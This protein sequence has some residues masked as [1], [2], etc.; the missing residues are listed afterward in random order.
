MG[1]VT[2]FLV[3]PKPESSRVHTRNYV[4]YLEIPTLEKKFKQTNEAPIILQPSSFTKDAD[5]AHACFHSSDLLSKQISDLQ[6]KRTPEAI[7]MTV[8]MTVHEQTKDQNSAKELS[9]INSVLR[10][11][12]FKVMEV[13]ASLD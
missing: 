6:G 13:R 11:K 10:C 3:I 7:E 2:N 5:S 8:A 12:A 4:S 1:P 9:S